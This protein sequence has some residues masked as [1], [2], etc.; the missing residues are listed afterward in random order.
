M[1]AGKP[2][3]F[4]EKPSSWLIHLR[5][6]VKLV[7]SPSRPSSRQVRQAVNENRLRP[8]LHYIV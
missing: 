7:E 8:S 2:V 1:P 4:A 6:V 3:K 5:V